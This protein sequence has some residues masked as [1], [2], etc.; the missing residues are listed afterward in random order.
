MAVS[1]CY[2]VII[3][4][5][6]TS[7]KEVFTVWMPDYSKKWHILADITTTRGKNKFHKKAEELSGI[8][9]YSWERA[10]TYDTNKVFE[11]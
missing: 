7:N 9:Y 8:D 3:M 1:L 10:I 11:A 5:N 2:K 6:K 4:S